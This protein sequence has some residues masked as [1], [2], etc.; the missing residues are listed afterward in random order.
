MG[1]N[2]H[3]GTLDK[4]KV[5]KKIAWIYKTHLKHTK[6]KTLGQTN[7][8]GMKVST[9]LAIFLLDKIILHMQE[10]SYT[11]YQHSCD[12]AIANH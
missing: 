9:T 4:F 5:K 8:K 3:N 2:G 12:V 7:M 10:C 1:H 6:K 11:E